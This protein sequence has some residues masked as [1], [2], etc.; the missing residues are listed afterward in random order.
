MTVTEQRAPTRAEMEAAYLEYR[1]ACYLILWRHAKARGLLDALEEPR[2]VDELSAEMGFRPERREHAGLL[3]DALARYGALE[4]HDDGRYSTVA[5]FEPDEI[6]RNLLPIAITAESI[7]NLLHSE[8][9]RGVLDTLQQEENLVAAKF[10]ADHLKVWTEFLGQP[11]YE[12]MRRSAVDAVASPRARVLD[13]GC[14]PGLGLSEIAETVGET[15]TVVGIEVSEDF[16]EEAR[17]RTADLPY[18]RVVHGDLD[19]GLPDL[20]EAPF[21]G[22]ILVGA[23]HF[24]HDHDRV[25]G[26]VAGV[27]KPGGR[28]SIGYAY[29]RR[30]SLDQELMDLRFAL[31]DPRPQAIEADRLVGTASGHGLEFVDRFDF[32][33][34]GWFLFERKVA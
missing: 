30:G 26:D 14:G 12:F 13:L 25:L 21:D 4:R 1:R 19:A 20:P 5:D 7:D 31:R 22:A 8:T 17:R 24:L 11:F 34:F 2:S 29:L 33:C 6:D 15:G 23:M 3:L 10:G 16:V 18:V 28:L 27:L 32:G 9:F